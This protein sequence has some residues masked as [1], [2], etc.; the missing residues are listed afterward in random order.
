MVLHRQP[1]ASDRVSSF[2]GAIKIPAEVEATW[3]TNTSEAEGSVTVFGRQ[4]QPLVQGAWRRRFLLTIPVLLMLPISVLAA[5]NLAVP[6]EAR[7]LLLLQEPGRGSPFLAESTAGKEFVQ[8]SNFE[9]PLK[10]ELEELLKSDLVLRKV[11]NDEIAAGRLIEDGKVDLVGKLRNN[12]TLRLI[13]RDFIDLRLRG[14]KAEGLGLQLDTV[15]SKFLET[16]VGEQGTSVG[17]VLTKTRR[18]NLERAKRD[19]TN[20]E[21]RLLRVLPGGLQAG[22]TR[23]RAITNALTA[24]REELAAIPLNQP[25]MQRPS[26]A[27]NTPEVS[28]GNLPSNRERDRVQRDIAKLETELQ[29]MSRA[30]FE[31]QK[32]VSQLEEARREIAKATEGLEAYLAKYGNIASGGANI[33]ILTAPERIRVLDLPRDPNHPIIDRRLYVILGMIAAIFLGIVLAWVAERLDQSVRSPAEFAAITGVP[34]VAR[35]SRI[36]SSPPAP[37]YKAIRRRLLHSIVL[38]LAAVGLVILVVFGPRVLHALSSPPPD[39]SAL[40]QVLA[41]YSSLL[42]KSLGFLS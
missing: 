32:L 2:P 25:E 10:Q 9:S 42:R 17:Q 33:L 20:L 13:G 38:A 23:L 36:P 19:A 16:L 21:A 12:L 3:G 35:L 4:L 34:V 1:E 18:D 31:H 30:M 28:A 29:A 27:K 39:F 41:D 24:K 14:S 11:V 40:W 6:Y 37:P 15:L 8:E 22:A 26:N 7:T 5:K